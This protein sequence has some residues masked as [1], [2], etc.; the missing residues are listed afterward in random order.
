M[1]YLLYPI[2]I[3]YQTQHRLL[4]KVQGLLEQAF[5]HFGRK[6]LG[7]SHE[8]KRLGLHRIS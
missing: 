2:Y 5:F 3:P 1:R 8:Q 7:T 4:V 6:S